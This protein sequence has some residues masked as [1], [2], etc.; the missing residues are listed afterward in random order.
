MDTLL[1]ELLYAQQLKHL[2]SLFLTILYPNRSEKLN[3][4]DYK[5]STFYGW[6]KEFVWQN[7]EKY[8]YEKY[9]N[10]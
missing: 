9:S 8:Q 10:S 1:L 3:I 6:A 7:V 5:S 2:N 4:Y